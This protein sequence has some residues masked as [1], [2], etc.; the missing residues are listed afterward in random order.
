MKGMPFY[1]SF[2]NSMIFKVYESFFIEV[3]GVTIFHF[4]DHCIFAP[5]SRPP[6]TS[7]R[8]GPPAG[9]SPQGV[10]PSSRP[11]PP[12]RR[13]SSAPRAPVTAAPPPIPLPLVTTA[14]SVPAKGVTAKWNKGN[15][16]VAFKPLWEQRWPLNRFHNVEQARHNSKK[17][18]FSEWTF[19]STK[20]TRDKRNTYL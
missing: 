1:K 6:A 19:C 8:A 13:P 14:Y 12:A 3:F 18:S 5:T 2:V 17:H 20:Q 7:P 4:L 16:M 15:M 9:S 10:A 11:R